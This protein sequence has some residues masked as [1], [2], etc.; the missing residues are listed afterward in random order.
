MESKLMS[1]VISIL[2]TK[3]VST[4]EQ[5]ILSNDLEHKEVFRFYAKNLSAVVDL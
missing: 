4:D 1:S 2:N 5:Q 3:L